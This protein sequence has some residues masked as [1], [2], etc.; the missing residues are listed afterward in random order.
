MGV[1]HGTNALFWMLRVDRS[2][3]IFPVDVGVS[4]NRGPPK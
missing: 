2:K 3:N 4:A 1:S